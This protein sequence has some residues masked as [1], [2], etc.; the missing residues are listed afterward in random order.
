LGV[1]EGILVKKCRKYPEDGGRKLLRNVIAF[2]DSHLAGTE[3]S[4]DHIQ[5]R[6]LRQHLD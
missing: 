4:I 6:Q 3:L 2:L 1:E 5:D